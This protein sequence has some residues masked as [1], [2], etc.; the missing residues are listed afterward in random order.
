MHGYLMP[1]LHSSRNITNEIFQVKKLSH[2]KLLKEEEFI[3]AHFLYISLKF[4]LE[5]TSYV[6]FVY[7]DNG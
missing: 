2:T 5:V 6:C 7:S 3:N 4:P 1:L